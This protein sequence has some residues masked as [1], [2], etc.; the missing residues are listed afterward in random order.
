MPIRHVV[1]FRLSDPDP[2]VRS[3]QAADAAE[4]LRG[5]VGVVPSL[6]AMDAG[7]NALDLPGNW[8]LVL[9]ADVDDAAGLDAYVTH[10]EHEKVAAFIGG[11][12][13]DRVAVD[14]EV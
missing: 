6:R 3:A 11:I 4:R 8:D 7:A 1:A 5:L 10:P 12:R 14:F 2:Q 9:V 13:A